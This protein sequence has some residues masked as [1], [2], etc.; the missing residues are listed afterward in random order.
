MTIISMYGLWAK[1]TVNSQIAILNEKFATMQ[2]SNTDE[3]SL[4]IAEALDSVMELH[5]PVDNEI[6]LIYPDTHFKQPICSQC[7]QM[8]YPC[9]T[10][11]AIREKLI[12]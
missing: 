2:A 9:P 5:K 7:V 6:G 10:I 1:A 11:E 4:I 12:P 3:I 8:I